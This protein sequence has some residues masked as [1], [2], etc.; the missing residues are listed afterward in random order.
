MTMEIQ[1]DM[2][3]IKF[4]LGKASTRKQDLQSITGWALAYSKVKS[5]NRYYICSE[6][7]EI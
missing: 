6:K 1:T 2:D 7:K 3:A 5:L 4:I